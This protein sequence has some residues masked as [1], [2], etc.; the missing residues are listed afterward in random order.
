M[1]NRKIR[2]AE[3]YKKYAKV[4]EYILLTKVAPLYKVCKYKVAI[5]AT[6]P[7]TLKVLQLR[8]CS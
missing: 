1:H 5:V 6:K 3:K 7:R 8:L 4:H 2:I